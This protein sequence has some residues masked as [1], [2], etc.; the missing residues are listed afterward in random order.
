LAAHGELLGEHDYSGHP[1][2][3]HWTRAAR[4]KWRRRRA[5]WLAD[6]ASRHERD[7]AIAAALRYAQRLVEEE[8][9]LEHAH[10]RVMRL[11]YVRGDRTA[12]LK[13][14][15]HC[16][17]TLRSI[18]DVDPDPE[19]LKLAEAIGRG[20]SSAQLPARGAQ[21]PVTLLRPPQMCGRHAEWQSACRA[22]DA[23]R[24]VLLRAEPGIGKTRMLQ[25]LAE[26]DPA[27][28]SFAARAGDR[29]WPYA[30]LLRMLQSLGPALNL[31]GWVTAELAHVWPQLDVPASG[32][33]DAYRLQQAA[34]QML[35]AWREA[36]SSTLVLLD[37]VQYADDATLELLPGL[38]GAE[39]LKGLR[40]VIAVRRAEV[41]PQIERW[42]ARSSALSPVDL[43]PLDV[44]AVERL[45]ASLQVPGIEGRAWAR[46]L[47]DHAG[48]NPLFL[49]ETVIAL[50]PHPGVVDVTGSLPV[51]QTIAGMV[52][53][54]L[55]RL[56]PLALKLARVASLSSPHFSLPLASR[57]LEVRPIDLVDAWAELERAG[58]LHSEGFAHDLL[59]EAIVRTVPA[60]IAAALHASIAADLASSGAEASH[61]ARHWMLAQDRLR[62]G[63]WLM[64]A[65]SAARAASQRAL[66]AE[67][68][69]QAIDCFDRSSAHDRAFDAR[70]RRLYS[71]RY[72]E[73]LA[74]QV[75]RAEKLV[76]MALGDEQRCIALEALAS[77]HTEGFDDQMVIQAATEARLLAIRHG[78]EM[79]EV[80]AAR[81]HAR[82]LARRGDGAA[83][84]TLVAQY[85]PTLAGR[86][87][88]DPEWAARSFAEF[89]CVMMTCDRP[90]DA[91]PLFEQALTIATAMRDWSLAQEC[92]SHVAWVHDY[93]GE[94]SESTLKYEA[95]QSLASRIG[96][97]RPPV[98]IGV[99]IHGRRCK[100]LGRFGD[101]LRLLE[102][103][104]AE[105][106]QAAYVP[107]GSAI[108]ADLANLYLWLGQTSKAI[109][110]V[111]SLDRA[112]PATMH[113]YHFLARAQIEFAQGG[114]PRKLLEHARTWA[115]R[116]G[117]AVASLIVELETLRCTR[118]DGACER[119][120][121]AVVRCERI[122][123]ALLEWPL[124]AVLVKSLL[125]S[126]Q[127]AEAAREARRVLQRIR[128]VPIGVLYTPEVA[129]ICAEAFT[130]VGETEAAGRAI[131]FAATWIIRV[132][133]PSVP[134][135]FRA[136][137][138]D[139]NP[140]N[141]SVLLASKAR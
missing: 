60:P 120:L 122:G 35:K 93:R 52:S 89:G 39:V 17:E 131:A 55:G 128:H 20:Q 54:R 12:S 96:V 84:L 25:E 133:L 6:L 97:V 48:G 99:S 13:A 132:A 65:A 124:R 26:R 23:G 7:L 72:F 58:F 135:E 16:I 56:S 136:S 73:P 110:V 42:C 62:A 19:T 47:L 31:A 33:L 2:L 105:M 61:V 75:E 51:P 10:R 76:A 103:A 108:E 101:A 9:S 111:R 15:E 22:L 69:E 83:A 70:V 78:D 85:V 112:A 123:L 134:D 24:S 57:V 28:V 14:Y 91:A 130:A 87:D 45:L 1:T 37:D 116:E 107:L 18:L 80:S 102:P 38:V 114:S 68:C 79:R 66:E 98:L 137:F 71:G 64:V 21:R 113:R 50:I 34:V 121:A 67:L 92:H 30:V 27:N 90:A 59:V 29:R 138:L 46:R 49:L 3:D 86:A 43:E 100:E 126:R 40:W 127:I 129:S 109:S 125:E 139:R 8:P 117:G 82:A 88:T 74:T 118:A 32:K 94:L 115:E 119:A 95:H 63:Q 41:P 44:E 4:E 5:D 140:T 77:V 104:Y 141:R 11:H 81:M 36:T 53:V 106:R